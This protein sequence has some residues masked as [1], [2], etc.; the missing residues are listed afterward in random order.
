VLLRISAAP[1]QN[2]I[3]QV[4]SGEAKP[5]LSQA[6]GVIGFTWTADG[7]LLVTD[8]SRLMKLDVDGKNQTQLLAD[9]S[10]AIYG[11]S[12]C[13]ANYFVFTWGLHGDALWANTWRVNTDGS[14]P[15]KLTSGNGDWLPVCSPD[16]KWVYSFHQG[17]GS[18]W[19]VRLDGSGK[20]EAV[21]GSNVPNV[22]GGPGVVSPDSK[23]F[24]Y[25]VEV[26]NPE[27]QEYR[28]KIA[29]L[30]LESS[31][32]LRMLDVSGQLGGWAD[33]PSAGVEFTPDGKAVAHIIRENGADNIWVQPL[34][35]SVGHRITNFTSEQI[36]SFHW[37]PDGKKLGILR[38]HS[39]SDVVLLQ[40]SKQ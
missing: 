12:A 35:G 4:N 15:L 8:S 27:T 20:P 25:L 26:L 11:P 7:N 29:L 19:R 30:N 23:T 33:V 34:D 10:A 36:S 24:A 13:G 40:E 38:G 21:P 32:A 3:G 9:S 17:D 31:T 22:S 28:S 6:N 14:S 16:Q 5:L 39:D 1:R 18:S 2:T 37:S